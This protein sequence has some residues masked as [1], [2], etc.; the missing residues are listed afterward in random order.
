[1]HASDETPV[2]ERVRGCELTVQRFEVADGTDTMAGA[3]V[4]GTADGAPDWTWL[5]QYLPQ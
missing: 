3:A 4:T 1:M 5:A 2:I